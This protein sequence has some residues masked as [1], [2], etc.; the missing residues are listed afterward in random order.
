[1]H[2]S[3]PVAQVFESSEALGARVAGFYWTQLLHC[4]YRLISSHELLGIPS[5]F[6][7]DVGSG[8]RAVYS[9]PRNGLVR[10]VDA[11]SPAAFARGLAAGAG[12]LAGGV[13]GGTAAGTAGLLNFVTSTVSHAAGALSFDPNYTYRRH[14][15]MQ[16]QAGS[17]GSGLRQGMQAMRL[18]LHAAASGVL[19]EPVRGAIDGGTAGFIKGV[20]RGLVGVV[21][22]PTSGLA[23]L[24]AK[25]SEGLASDAKR[26]TVRGRS[27]QERSSTELRVRQPRELGAD[28]V[29]LPYPA[30]PSL[31]F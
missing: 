18:G 28:V 20:G 24:V 4:I 30:A 21:A 5:R 1:M 9:E 12:S 14:V 17:T 11:R 19:Q 27:E 13:L 25:T 29:L 22:K 3:P 15:L 23:A 7:T 8:V 10:A 31:R 2:P 26:V 6:F 16:Q